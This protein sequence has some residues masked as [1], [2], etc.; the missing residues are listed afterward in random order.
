[1]C[2]LIIVCAFLGRTLVHHAVKRFMVIAPAIFFKLG[3]AFTLL[4]ITS[5][6]SINNGFI[7]FLLVM[8]GLSNILA[9]LQARR[10]PVSTNLLP[11][12]YQQY[13]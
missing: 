11:L 9:N 7:G 5:V 4:L 8:M 12:P 3:I 1:M 13:G 2:I 6:V 10:P